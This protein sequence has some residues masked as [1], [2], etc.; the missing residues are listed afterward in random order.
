MATVD[1]SYSREQWGSALFPEISSPQ[2]ALAAGDRLLR[3]DGAL[4]RDLNGIFAICSICSIGIERL[5]KLA[6]GISA[7]SDGKPW[8]QMNSRAKEDAMLVPKNAGLCAFRMIFSE[9]T[10]SMG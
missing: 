3:A 9:M 7:A 10:S 2:S 8:P 6:L 4:E 1:S 5:P